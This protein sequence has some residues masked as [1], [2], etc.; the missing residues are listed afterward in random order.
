MAKKRRKDKAEAEQ[1]YEFRPP[2]FDEKE[3]LRKELRDT[4]AVLIT[5]GYAAFFG[6]LAAVITMVNPDLV[7]VGLVL[8]V[9][10]IFS[11]KFFYPLVKVDV[12]DFAKKNWAGNIAWFFF[13]FLAVWVLL[14]N[15]PFSDHAKPDVV[16][17]TV[18]IYNSDTQ[19]LTAV[20]YRYSSSDGDWKWVPR[21]GTTT[22]GLLKAT[23]TYTVNITA[24]VS[25]NGR[26]ETV[27]IAV[28]SAPSGYVAMTD[29]GDQ[30]YGYEVSGA[31]LSAASDLMFYIEA[32]DEAGNDLTFY[33][34]GDP[35]PV[36]A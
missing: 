26:L 19:N 36:T 6:I 22:E 18:W 10:G 30:R 29:E 7:I 28:G 23:D 35:F 32:V 9:A 1:E 17:V 33:P 3:F 5:V 4:R 14:F 27:R 12:K 20:D 24:T 31:S 25:D 8:V 11:L 15:Y 16:D 2:E 34:A 13:T 21:W